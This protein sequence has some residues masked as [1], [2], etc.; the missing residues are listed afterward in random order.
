M[1]L[2]NQLEIRVRHGKFSQKINQFKVVL[3]SCHYMLFTV[4]V[5]IGN[6]VL[7]TSYKGEKSTN[8]SL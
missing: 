4:L 1:D 5:Q 7:E 2:Y 8:R 6:Q 3:T